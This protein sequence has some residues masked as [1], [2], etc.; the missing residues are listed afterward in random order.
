[1]IVATA[2]RMAEGM[3][4]HLYT[5]RLP[6]GQIRPFT[7]AETFAAYVK[8]WAGADFYKVWPDKFTCFIQAVEA[9]F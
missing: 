2:G 1:M 7:H 6:N 3:T 8:G 4:L 9:P 5:V